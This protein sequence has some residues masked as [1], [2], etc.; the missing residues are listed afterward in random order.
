MA[1][2]IPAVLAA[3][4]LGVFIP[5]GDAGAG[6]GGRDVLAFT[7]TTDNRADTGTRVRAGSS[8]R[9]VYTVVNKAEY[10]VADLLLTDPQVPGGAI[11]CP[12]G[13]ARTASLAGRG[14]VVC[15]A[16]FP[17]E[18]GPRIGPV[19]ASGRTL[20]RGSDPSSTVSAGYHGIASGLAL[21]RTAGGDGG[22]V[23][24]GGP[25]ELG[26]TVT[27]SGD[28]PVDVAR[29]ADPLLGGGTPR[30]A[31]SLPVR[32]APGTSLACTGRAKAAA[33]PRSGTARVTG[34]AADGTVDAEGRAVPPLALTAEAPGAYTGVVAGASGAPG[35]AA[36][37]A[38]GGDAAGPGPGGA[39]GS[40]P[41][42]VA[43]RFL[44]PPPVPPL[45][46]TGRPGGTAA[47]G[48]PGSAAEVPDKQPGLPAGHDEASVSLGA[49]EWG[50]LLF[51]VAL[52]PVAVAAATR[53]GR[54][55]KTG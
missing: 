51:L 9:R 53:A 8:V 19:T 20:P 17:A 40:V 26:Y 37:S 11:R 45:G 3:V 43:R 10:P 5:A 52:V 35:G 7:V 32:L 1:R 6:D 28:V 34:S 16:E 23:P 49:W 18:P 13:G 12:D 44:P 48:S 4:L 39:V 47:P 41:G 25:L 42:G 22:P 14:R 55:K 31:R 21:A 50:G 33:G 27:V 30:C 46:A 2:R 38:P 36:G 24:V 15:T 54:D 29:L